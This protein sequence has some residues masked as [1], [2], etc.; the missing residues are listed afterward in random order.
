MADRV[1][2][3]VGAPPAGTTSL[4]Q[5][6]WAD[7]AALAR[8]GVTYPGW[9]PDAHALACQ[10]LTGVE[11]G[12]WPD[13]DVVG[14]WRRLLDRTRAARGTVVLSS[15]LLGDASADV[16]ERVLADLAPA[17]VHVVVTVRDPTGPSSAPPGGTGDA[18]ARPP[19]VPPVL[20]RWAAALPADRV[21]VLVVPPG[22]AARDLLWGQFATVLG[23]RPEAAAPRPRRG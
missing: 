9:R 20:R 23:V 7:R 14:A 8:A 19:D 1:V 10:D 18:A 5:Q 16:A 6:F 21:H 12:D 13:P 22:G 15:E 2:L 11:F 17:E 4:P 3:H